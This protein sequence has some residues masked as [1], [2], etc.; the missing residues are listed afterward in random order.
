MVIVCPSRVT[1]NVP[2]CG[3]WRGGRGGD[4]LF[5]EFRTE[6]ERLAAAALPTL[7]PSPPSPWP[8]RVPPHTLRLNLVGRKWVVA[9]LWWPDVLDPGELWVFVEE[10]E[11]LGE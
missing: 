11:L 3:G 1:A 5:H 8:P 7:W 9:A 6:R 10:R 4:E 2:D